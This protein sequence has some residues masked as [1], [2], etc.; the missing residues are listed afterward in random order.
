MSRNRSTRGAAYVFLA[1]PE[2]GRQAVG[3]FVAQCARVVVFKYCGDRLTRLTNLDWGDWPLCPRPPA[4]VRLPLSISDAATAIQ[5]N[6]SGV[7][8]AGPAACANVLN[9]T[10][11]R[12][13]V[14]PS[15]LNSGS[16]HAFSS[17]QNP[18]YESRP[19]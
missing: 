5:H 2:V 3:F 9:A 11:A 8:Q 15:V 18:G 13:S 19:I 10:V 4:S 12:E 7:L 1:V 17:Q 6:R 14:C 16:G